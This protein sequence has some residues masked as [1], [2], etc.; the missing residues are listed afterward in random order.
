[1]TLPGIQMRVI[2]RD[3]TPMRGRDNTDTSYETDTISIGAGE[4]FDVIFT[5][6]PYQGPGAYDTYMLYNRSFAR[7]NNQAP[8]GYGGQAT[9]VRVF[10]GG[11][12]GAQTV[13]NT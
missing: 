3:A 8:G 7:A 2:G 11:T 12:I 1:M 10:P 5:A 4:S 9:E 6:P 13:P